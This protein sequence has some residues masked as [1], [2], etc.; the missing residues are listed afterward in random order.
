MNTLRPSYSSVS[1][2]AGKLAA[3]AFASAIA[4]GGDEPG[5]EPKKK[6]KAK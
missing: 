1:A 2:N 5:L 3:S 6:K 4:E